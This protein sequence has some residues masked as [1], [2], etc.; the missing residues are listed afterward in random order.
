MMN[1]LVDHAWFLLW[2][3]CFRPPAT[4]QPAKSLKRIVTPLHHALETPSRS[5]PTTA[6]PAMERDSY[7]GPKD[8]THS[9]AKG[10][11]LQRDSDTDPLYGTR[12]A[13]AGGDLLNTPPT[14]T[15]PLSMSACAMGD[16]RCQRRTRS[17]RLPT[18][19]HH[20]LTGTRPRSA[21]LAP[22]AVHR[23]PSP[24]KASHRGPSVDRAMVRRCPMVGDAPPPAMPFPPCWPW[25]WTTPERT[26]GDRAPHGQ[27]AHRLHTVTR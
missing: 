21:A 25:T 1:A 2:R 14:P 8:G 20:P 19:P 22:L 5:A 17:S 26:D 24:C 9:P 6:T 12:Y 10:G 15:A 23:C 3:P 4:D 7:M 13:F 16:P 27:G 11:Y 18:P